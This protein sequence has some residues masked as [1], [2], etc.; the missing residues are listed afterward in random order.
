[1]AA[2]GPPLL[3]S[4]IMLPTLHALNNQ[5]FQREHH[6]DQL[7][8]QTEAVE[9][10]VVEGVER[11]QHDQAVQEGRT[12]RSEACDTHPSRMSRGGLTVVST[13]VVGS[14]PGVGPPLTIRSTSAPNARSTSSA[15]VAGGCPVRF[16]LVPVRGPPMTSSTRW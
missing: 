4:L 15:V 13:T 8:G 7:G 6:D 2:R 3:D 1:L 11:R 5:L 9:E 16:A 14:P 10:L 12:A